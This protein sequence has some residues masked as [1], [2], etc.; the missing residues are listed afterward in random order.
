M[1]DQ[2]T[3]KVLA[4]L[5]SVKR[6]PPEKVTLDSSFEELGLDS[7]DTLNVLFELENEFQI[8]IPDE[9][10][11]SIRNVRGIV[12]GVKKLIANASAGS[13]AAGA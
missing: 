9:E 4:T 13:G 6:L 3:E 11:R 5:A 2:V 7:L 8:S 1:S 10:A 12:D